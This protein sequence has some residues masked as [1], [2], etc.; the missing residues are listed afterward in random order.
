MLA[1]LAEEELQRVG[2]RLDGLTAA[3]G[4]G[5]PPPSPARR[6]ARSLCGRA[7]GSRP[8]ARAARARAARGARSARP[9]AP[10][11]SPRRLRAAP[12]APRSRGSN[13]SRPSTLLPWSVLAC[14]GLFPAPSHN[15][16][17]SGLPKSSD[18]AARLE[19]SG[20]TSAARARERA[21]C[22]V[23]E[24]RRGTADT[25]SARPPIRLGRR[26]SPLHVASLSTGCTNRCGNVD[27]SKSA[28]CGL[29]VSRR[30]CTVLGDPLDSQVR[31][32]R[33]ESRS[34]Q[35]RRAVRGGPQGPRSESQPELWTESQAARRIF[36]TGA[37]G[38]GPFARSA[39]VESRRVHCRT[40][41]ASTPA[42]WRSSGRSLLGALR[43][44]RAR[45]DRRDGRVRDRDRAR[46]RSRRSGSSSAYAAKTGRAPSPLRVRD[47]LGDPSPESAKTSLCA[48][49]GPSAASRRSPRRRRVR[50]EAQRSGRREATS[51]RSCGTAFIPLFL[52]GTP[53]APHDP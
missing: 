27:Y 39:L 20:A 9:G 24:T 12:Q 17:T 40:R 23:G 42:S 44:L 28:K 2:R 32:A 36:W 41:P 18:P 45:R 53:P 6:R 19:L 34:K 46:S 43:L 1:G 11:R 22:Q 15:P 16:N 29:F 13:R 8:R 49:S 25:L 50:V 37:S 10:A 21:L 7:P 51:P 33:S 14:P 35:H 52:S 26:A 4:V 38:A 3:G 47:V 5:E 31:R 48:S 30:P